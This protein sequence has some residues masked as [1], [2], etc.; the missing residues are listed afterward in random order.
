MK[1]KHFPLI[2]IMANGIFLDGNERNMAEIGGR[3]QSWE[4]L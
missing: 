3:T 2:P 4:N 1:P